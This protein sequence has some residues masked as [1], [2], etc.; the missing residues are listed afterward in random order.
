MGKRVSGNSY[1]IPSITY[2]IILSMLIAKKYIALIYRMVIQE[3]TNMINILYIIFII[4]IIFQIIMVG[5]TKK[6][7]IFILISS[8]IFLSSRENSLIV[9]VLLA[10]SAK[11]VEDDT[12][13]KQYLFI[14][15]IAFLAVVTLRELSI[16][17][18]SPVLHYRRLETG[19]WIL[20]KDFG[21]GN[22][23][24]VFFNLMPI[25]AAYI[26]LRF[27]KYN[28][29]DRLIIFISATYIYNATDTRAGYIVIIGLMF[30]IEIFKK[31]DMDKK[32]IVNKFFMKIIQYMP[33]ILLVF[34]LI[35]GTIFSNNQALN[36]IL[37]GRP[38]YWN[39]YIKNMNLIGWGNLVKINP[40]DNSYIYMFCIAG[41]I[42][43]VI[44]NSCISKGLKKAMKDNNKK[45]VILILSFLIFGMSENIILDS[46]IN[47]TFIIL[48]KQFLV[49][50]TT[51][52]IQRS[53]K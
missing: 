1:T 41:I 9:F 22:P 40:L 25:Y 29:L 23:N 21:L 49:S 14:S 47:F 46:S 51:K 12:I 19:E 45:L 28:M 50:K 20:R 33:W 11:N 53:Y 17:P 2:F 18:Q 13:I 26:Y 36:S 4:L 38:S 15:L 52:Q 16:I 43:T 7:L 44:V 8:I 6:D 34:S 37:S 24:T 5:I 27:N 39:Y 3:P 35:I 42:V 31:V 10:I 48:I 30:L 32:T